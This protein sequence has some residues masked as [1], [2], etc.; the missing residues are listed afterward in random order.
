MH[1][2][3]ICDASIVDGTGLKPCPGDIAIENGLITAI[4]NL[5]GESARQVINAGGRVVAPGFVDIHT[6]YDGQVTWDDE[7]KPSSQHGVTTVVMGN[8][9]VGFAPVDP[10]ARRGS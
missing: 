2:I 9:G 1:D 7:L 3:L 10:E 5:S 6:H 4:G 8:C